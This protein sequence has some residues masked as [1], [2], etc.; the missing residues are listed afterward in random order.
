MNSEFL[1]W[2]HG[3]LLFLAY[4]GTNTHKMCHVCVV[5][6]IKLEATT[7]YWFPSFIKILYLCNNCLNWEL[8]SDMDELYRV[9]YS[10]ISSLHN[11]NNFLGDGSTTHHQ[12][13]EYGSQ[14]HDHDHG[15][16]ERSDV[17]KAQIANHPLYPTLLSS[18][19]DCRKVGAPPEM[20]SVLEEIGKENQPICESTEI[21]KDP[22]LD[23]F[24]K[25][26][27]D[28]L[29]KCKEELSKPFDEATNFLSSIGSQLTHLC[30]QT[31]LPLNQNGI[32]NLSF[33]SFYIYICIN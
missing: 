2:P 33:F 31:Q 17:I 4:L 25:S 18:Y 11:N 5:G 30:N 14:I 24:M 19:I 1:A 12:N 7:K 3:I 22:E 16:M 23:H 6:C 27:C 29:H 15:S 28:A 21:G 9:H 13:M 26:Y 10:S 32:L 8:A 20:A